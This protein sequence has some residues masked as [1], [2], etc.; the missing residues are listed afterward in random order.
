MILNVFLP[1]TTSTPHLY[2]YWSLCPRREVIV[3][4]WARDLVIWQGIQH[5]LSNSTKS[6]VQLKMPPSLDLR[7]MLD[8]K[9]MLSTK[10]IPNLISLVFCFQSEVPCVHKPK[11]SDYLST[12]F[13]PSKW[14]KENY[15]KKGMIL[16]Y[17]LAEPWL[18]GHGERD[19]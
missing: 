1:I 17:L 13:F 19:D 6:F 16:Y 15:L 8:I 10:S 5:H 2:N 12:N 9:P 7:P 14:Y 11:N 3:I 4:T 18:A